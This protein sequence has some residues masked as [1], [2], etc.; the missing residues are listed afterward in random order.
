MKTPEAMRRTA[1]TVWLAALT[2]IGGCMVGPDYHPPKNQP[3]PAWAGLTNSVAAADSRLT[4]SAVELAR[5]WDQFQD[6]EL[7]ALVTEALQTNLDVQLAQAQVREARATIGKDAGGL[8]PSLT[9]SGSAS[10]SGSVSTSIIK[11]SQGNHVNS[12]SAGLAALWN[13]DFFGATRRQLEA[14]AAALDAACENLHGEEVTVSSSVALDYIQIRGAQEQIAIAQTNLESERHTAEVTRR[15]AAAGFD[16]GLDQANADAQV[17]STAASIPPLEVTIQQNIFALSILLGRPPAD[18]LAD[19]SK[20]GP[21]PITPPEVP[22]GLPS[23]LLRRRPD[24]RQAEAS[25]HQAAAE[26]GA[27]VADFY[28]QF[29]LTGNITYQNS[30][31]RELFA[32]PSGSLSAGPQVNWPI[33]Q[34]GSTIN[35]LRY[36][37]AARDAAYISYQKTV[38]AAL[39]DVEYYLVSFAKEWDH[40]KALSDSVVFNRRALTLSQALYQAGTTEFLTVLDAERSVLG[41]ETE[42]AQSRQAIASDLVNIYRAL[43]GGWEETKN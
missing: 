37:K 41:S 21:I 32:G 24:I 11:P 9:A 40:R 16:S 29:S 43:G 6:P 12:L 14:D 39:S 42:L 17:A 31:A 10:R 1:L 5:W 23:D 4:N 7:T 22:V 18:L 8:F 3:P 25:L 30:L 15:K 27:A 33:F 19:L 20:P 28:P 13:L 35:N 38:L 26:I 34:G 2:L 36:Q